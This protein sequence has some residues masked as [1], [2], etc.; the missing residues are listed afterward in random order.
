MTDP[1][2]TDKVVRLVALRRLG[3]ALRLNLDLPASLPERLHALL[4]QL[5]HSHAEVSG[6]VSRRRP[7]TATGH[8][9][10]ALPLAYCDDP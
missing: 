2:P 8:T 4:Q 5:H 6:Y 1:I 10:T 9:N 3:E 7:D